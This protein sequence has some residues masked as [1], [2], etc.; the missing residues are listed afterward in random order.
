MRR[1]VATGTRGIALSMV[2]VAVALIASFTLLALQA[3]VI[4]VRLAA[5]A[6]GRVEGQLVAATALAVARVA[7]RA[8]LDTLG[9]GA[10]VVWP[11]VIRPDGWS[12]QAQATRTGAVIRLIA[13]AERRSADGAVYAARRASLLLARDAADTVRVLDHRPRF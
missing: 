8:D 4:Q 13:V 12:W 11:A 7:H 3:A 6:R 2:L 1:G 10:T 5:D 9:D